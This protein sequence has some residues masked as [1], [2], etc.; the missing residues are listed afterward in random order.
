MIMSQ[1]SESERQEKENKKQKKY[2][3]YKG[4]FVVG[5]KAD[6]SPD[7]IYVR[8]RS[9]AERDDKLAEAKRLHARG[10]KAGEMTVREWSDIWMKAYK[11]NAT[12]K[13]K[14]HYQAKLDYDIL[15]AIGNMCVK[16]VRASHLQELLNAYTGGRQGTVV[17]VRLALKQLFSDAEYDGIIERNPSIRLELPDVVVKPRRP[18]TEVER[19]A[20]LSAAEINPQ[21]PFMLT[22]LYC[23][24]RTGECAA[25]LCGDVD[26]EGR[27]LSITKSLV[28]DGNKSVM[29]T[30]KAEKLRKRVGENDDE[31]GARVV[32][33]PDILLPILATQCEGR[34]SEDVLFPKKTD[35]KHASRRALDWWW[36]SFVRQCHICAGAKMYRN[37]I[38]YEESPFGEDVTPHYFRHTYGTDLYGAGV[39][40]RARK[41][42]LG[43]SLRDVTDIYTKMTD[44]AFQ[45]NLKLINQYHKE[46]KWGKNGANKKGNKA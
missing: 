13:Q 20:V 3:Y 37:A 25:L 45:R 24:P 5:K 23:G 38:V 39:D 32:P 36:E 35:G 9:K 30:T 19:R 29:S 14:A 17:K 4:S 46:E 40:L 7:R 2:K 26:I 27:S 21:G 33:I 18:L 22:L 12:A 31:L 11:H 43:H 42:F 10:L 44:A 1:K 15:P 34:K 8:G 28:F 16:D 41:E 6:G